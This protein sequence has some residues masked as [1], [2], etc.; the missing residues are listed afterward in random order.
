MTNQSKIMMTALELFSAQ[1]IRHVTVDEL[2]RAS[3]MSKRTIYSCFNDK[4]E[5]VS[6]LYRTLLQ[7]MQK[8]L[9]SIREEADNAV[10]ELVRMNKVVLSSHRFFTSLVIDD[11]RRYYRETFDEVYTLR[12]QF[13]PELFSANIEYGIKT[14]VYNDL[15]NPALMAEL[16]I[17]E[18][19]YLWQ[20]P[21]GLVHPFSRKEINQQFLRHFFSGLVTG[22]GRIILDECLGNRAGYSNNN[23][24]KTETK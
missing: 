1:G 6:T 5:I 12:T 23:L 24:V 15:F 19:T 8:K 3:G 11:L 2:A 17:H 16:A 9:L 18:L 22:K 20:Q 14:G 4:T 7:Q 10:S 13:L 21:E